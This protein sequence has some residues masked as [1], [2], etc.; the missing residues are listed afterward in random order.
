MIDVVYQQPSFW[1]F[2]VEGL[3]IGLGMLLVAAPVVVG[4]IIYFNRPEPRKPDPNDRLPPVDRFKD[5]RTPRPP[6]RGPGGVA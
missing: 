1:Q 6:R 5:H 2:V 3:G 4:G